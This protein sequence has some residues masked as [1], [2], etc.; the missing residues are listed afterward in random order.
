VQVTEIIYKLKNLA[1]EKMREITL[2]SLGDVQ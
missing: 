2:K 1:V